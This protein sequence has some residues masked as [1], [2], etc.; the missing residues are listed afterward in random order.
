MAETLN[1]VIL[2]AVSTNEQ[3]DDDKFS[4][5]AQIAD[6]RA[7]A[8][9]NGWHVADVI[10]IEGHS[11]N[12][13]TLAQLAAAA[14]TNNEPGFDRLIAHFEKRDFDILICRDANRFARKASLLYEIVD[15]IL[16]DCRA[17]IYSLSDGMVDKS[18]ADMWCMVK[19]YET[20]KQ[21][22]WIKEEM[23]R[24]RHKLV[25]ERG[26]PLHGQYVW[27]HMKVR[28]EKG[29]TTA[30]IP[31]PAKSDVIHAAAQLVV[32]RVAWNRLE[33]Q[34]FEKGW[35]ENGKPYKRLFFYK[36]FTNPWFWGDA[37]RNHHNRFGPNSEKIQLWSIDQSAPVPEGVVIKR[38]INPPAITGDLALRLRA[39]IIRR[40]TTHLRNH[41]HSHPFTG[42]L[43]CQ[44]CGF[45]MQ[46]S[47]NGAY[48]GYYCGSKYSSRRK[49]DPSQRPGCDKTWWVSEL[50]VT[51]WV[52]AA[53]TKMLEDQNP[54][55]LISTESEAAP[56]NT[57]VELSHQLKALEKQI[58]RLIEKQATAP[59]SLTDMY[60][61]QIDG[62]A[63]QRENLLRRVDEVE[64]EARRYNVADIQDAFRE[65]STYETLEAFWAA[66]KG[67]INQLLH[68]L[69]GQP[70]L[71][72]FG[73]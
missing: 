32:D 18:N 59:E 8:E 33:E 65:L 17:R 15:I 16:E 51:Q 49:H 63:H 37:A 30:F 3:A 55:G 61:A 50:Y 71:G 70:P 57:L 20:N 5:D 66:D 41:V 11:R 53:L 44:R 73:S 72:R 45:T 28:D 27:S 22:K 42:L 14:R 2:A 67:T 43:I 54:L 25:E 35:G 60:D 24:A 21:M 39:E 64:R 26:I 34:L 68:R 48:G 46:Y 69:D 47:S 9:K 36:L 56:D 10:R 58:Q 23:V 6:S 38:N 13:R 1:A 4:L 52:T 62:L 40:M 12:Y 19:G 29:K 7:V 31:D